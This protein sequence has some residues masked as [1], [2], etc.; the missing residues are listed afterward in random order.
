LK[1]VKRCTKLKKAVG[2]LYKKLDLYKIRCMG[3]FKFLREN[4]KN[5]IAIHLYKFF[6]D[7]IRANE[8]KATTLQIKNTV[9][10]KKLLKK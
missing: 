3:L 7:C 1:D 4:L 6:P 5:Q 8:G 10:K 2:Q 9:H